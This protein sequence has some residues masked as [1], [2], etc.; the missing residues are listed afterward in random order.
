M[1]TPERD[2]PKNLHELIESLAENTYNIHARQRLANAKSSAA[3]SATAFPPYEELP[4]AEKQDHRNTAVE[5]LKL[6]LN[7]GF[8]LEP[9]KLALPSEEGKG[10]KAAETA[11]LA[12]IDAVNLPSAIALWLSHDPEEWAQTPE[13]YRR[14]GR[15][16]L[17]LG[18]PLLAYDILTEGL[19]NEPAD[20]G[21]RQQVALSLA[22]SGATQR[23]N[24]ILTQ[25]RAEGHR[26]E[27][28]LAILARTHKDLWTHATVKT[29][30]TRQLKLAH[31]FYLESYKLNRGYYSAI[32]TATLALLLGKKDEAGAL[33]QQARS[34]CLAE[35]KTLPA[36]SEHRY[37]PLATLGEACLILR[38]FSEAEDW[39]A[40]AAKAGRGNYAE[41]S[42][43]RRNARLL[44]NHLQRDSTSIEQALKIPDIVV[45]AGHLIDQ[46]ERAA[47]RFPAQ[48]EPAVREA[49]QK[50]VK[51]I[52]P[53]FG[54]ASGACGSDILFLEAMLERGSEANVVL[55]FAKEQFIQ[56]SVAFAGSEWLQ[57][58]ESVLERAT[59][60]ITASSERI[61]EG[62]MSFEY[63]NLLLYGLAD[64]RARQLETD[65]VPLAVWDQKPG[66]GPG[67]TA[68]AV[69][70]WRNLG[71]DV[72]VIDLAKILKRGMPVGSGKQRSVS[73]SPRAER[74]LGGE[75]AT[76]V[77]PTPDPSPHAGTAETLPTRIMA[78]LFADAVNFS[79]LTEQQIPLFL[80]HFLGAIGKL[81]STS[82]HAP[83]IKNTWGDGLYFVFADVRDAGL[84][85]LDLCELM[86]ST[87]WSKKGLPKA[88]NLRIALHAGPVYSC[89][90]PVTG[91]ASFTGT[92]VSRAARIEPITPPGQVYASQAFAAL[93][94]AQ[95][96]TEFTCDYVGQT[97]LAKGYGTFATYHVRN[98][99]TH[100]R[101]SK[102]TK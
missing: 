32:N 73:P 3:R 90:D 25:L 72:Q 30:R 52:A 84:F 83:S 98:A 50:Q 47:P 102:R 101:A 20:V 63:A 28:T 14:L 71:R 9:P 67:G 33:A 11:T 60:V 59:T 45:F 53:G 99:N 34:A 26:D 13:I 77:N 81:I 41:L 96:V 93:S 48:L 37:W 16:V 79:K 44:L 27:E 70:H 23:S 2:L 94:A 69:A 7:R 4:D 57:R 100:S 74:G 42:S 55:P 75:V 39:Y 17:K 1:H 80:N 65:L 95:G 64:I 43:T 12:L 22:R 5:T 87:D 78:M 68:S 40:Q 38:R 92:H 31:K 15:R 29:E 88:I 21:M 19:K 10:P 97:P 54:Y 58:F 62:S 24:A 61:E 86:V 8:K 56:D 49:I 91:L 89:V 35:I 76:R 46:A 6:I 82:P 85:A 51:K 66:D 36:N 18:E